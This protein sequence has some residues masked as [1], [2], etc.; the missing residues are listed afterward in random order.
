MPPS[1][2]P[3]QHAINVATAAVR[4]KKIGGTVARQREMDAAAVRAGARP[5]CGVRPCA[6]RASRFSPQAARP[7]VRRPPSR[8]ETTDA[9]LLRARARERACAGLAVF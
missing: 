9:G 6:H 3:L 7:A 1:P 2:P 5:L 4:W 8:V